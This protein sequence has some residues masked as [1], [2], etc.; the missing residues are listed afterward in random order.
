VRRQRWE[1]L[2]PQIFVVVLSLGSAL[3]LLVMAVALLPRTDPDPMGAYLGIFA[4]MVLLL[5]LTPL[6]GFFMPKLSIFGRL[7]VTSA[8]LA[9]ALEY[10]RLMERRLGVGVNSFAELLPFL[11]LSLPGMIALVIYCRAYN[12]LSRTRAAD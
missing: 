7:G 4:G 8:L 10:A 1:R 2:L 3:G 9:G 11:G 5:L 6:W 12:R